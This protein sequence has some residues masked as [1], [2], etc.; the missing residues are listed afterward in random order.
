MGEVREANA[1]LSVR[2]WAPREFSHDM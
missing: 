2:F 1:Q